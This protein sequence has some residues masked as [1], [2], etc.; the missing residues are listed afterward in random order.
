MTTSIRT[1]AFAAATLSSLATL[2][3]ETI[4]Q[5]SGAYNPS[6]ST[7]NTPA[8]WVGN[9]TVV[10][11]NDYQTVADPSRY[12][13]GTAYGT[14]FVTATTTGESK[15]WSYYAQV[16][17]FGSA[18][19]P[20]GNL[21]FDGNSLIVS[22]GTRFLSKNRNYT[23]TA[24]WVLQDNSYLHLSPGGTN[25]QTTNGTGTFAGTISVTGNT[26][27]GFE[28]T[29]ARAQG[30]IVSADISG[31]GLLT[32]TGKGGDA[33]TM[34]LTGNL[35]QFTGTF[36]VTSSTGNSTQAKTSTPITFS[37]ASSASFATLQLNY[38]SPFFRYDLSTGDVS[39][40]SLILGVGDTA[41][42]LGAGTYDAD[43]L[44][45]HT[46]NA[47]LFSG[48][49][50]ITVVPEPSTAALGAFAAIVMFAA[51]RRQRS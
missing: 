42:V 40:S 14:D 13:S 44:N 25:A 45:G 46:G 35:D 29:S 28:T 4:L 12:P 50:T 5:S 3:A 26:L 17:D 11:T 41:E 7:W 48:I 47:N 33:A 32:L 37:I 38:T 24:N 39:F 49:G 23:T 10:N 30:F 1:I 43:F 15:S 8:V 9:T 36:L 27:I 19:V 2:P 6:T 51:Y 20:S 16:R 22:S 18:G 31:S 21:A 34:S